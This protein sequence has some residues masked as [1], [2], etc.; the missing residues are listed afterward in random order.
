MRSAY[1][2]DGILL[3][4][5][6]AG[7]D[8]NIDLESRVMPLDQGGDQGQALAAIAVAFLPDEAMGPSDS[9]D[10]K[11]FIREELAPLDADTRNLVVDFL[12]RSITSQNPSSRAFHALLHLREVL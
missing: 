5:L 10:L 8:Q 6:D 1:L 4:A 11:Q 12:A 2:S 3:L 9:L 7:E